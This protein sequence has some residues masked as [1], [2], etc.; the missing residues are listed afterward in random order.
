VQYQELATLARKRETLLGWLLDFVLQLAIFTL[1]LCSVRFPISFS[2]AAYAILRVVFFP[3]FQQDS[4]LPLA[5]QHILIS[6][7]LSTK[8]GL[9]RLLLTKSYV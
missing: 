3:G 9:G 5:S 6:R 7:R 4:L 8:P 2:R 1:L